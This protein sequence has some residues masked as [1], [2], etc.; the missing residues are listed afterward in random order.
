MLHVFRLGRNTEDEGA[1]AADVAQTS[2]PPPMAS[3]RRRA[4]LRLRPAPAEVAVC[5]REA[6]EGVENLFQ[7]GARGF[8]GRCPRRRQPRHHRTVTL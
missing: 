4:M 6:D 3:M 2:M 8:R 5:A 1:A 7:V